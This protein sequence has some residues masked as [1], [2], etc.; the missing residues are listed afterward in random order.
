V[1]VRGANGGC[2]VAVATLF[3]TVMFVDSLYGS[4]FILYGNVC[5]FS[6]RIVLYFVR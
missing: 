2:Q 4:C 5:G 6:A 1:C 3:C